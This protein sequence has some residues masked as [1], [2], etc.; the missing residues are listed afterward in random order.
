M[1]RA[2][3][4]HA[5]LR[6]QS[7]HGQ[8]G[9]IRCPNIYVFGISTTNVVIWHYFGK[10]LRQFLKKIFSFTQGSP[11]WFLGYLSSGFWAK[12]IIFKVE[13]SGL[14][15]TSSG[16]STWTFGEKKLLRLSIVSS[17]PFQVFIHGIFVLQFGGVCSIFCLN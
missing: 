12:S 8:Y 14:H 5:I 2:R 15:Q 17:V 6:A 9:A 16:Y 10:D 1:L 11:L 3:S 4:V 7:V 13:S